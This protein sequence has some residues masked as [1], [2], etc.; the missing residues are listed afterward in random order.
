[1]IISR[2][3]SVHS[4]Y[5]TFETWGRFLKKR[6]CRCQSGVLVALVIAVL[7]VVLAVAAVVTF[8]G[9]VTAA[10]AAALAVTCNQIG[11]VET[12]PR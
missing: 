10:G 7:G 3:T 2:T 4:L 11:R 1:M 12:W 8:G 5:W 9:G 6:D